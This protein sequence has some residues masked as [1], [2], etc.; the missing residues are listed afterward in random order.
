[1]NVNGIHVPTKWGPIVSQVGANHSR[2]GRYVQPPSASC[3][4][5]LSDA[6]EEGVWLVF[7]VCFHCFEGLGDDKTHGTNMF[8]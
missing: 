8:G 3:D 5:G 4:C 2:Y 6:F 7:V 1:M